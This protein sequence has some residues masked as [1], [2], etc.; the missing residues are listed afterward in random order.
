MRGELFGGL[1]ET[2]Q[3]LTRYAK[4]YGLLKNWRLFVNEAIK[5]I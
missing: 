5:T 2:E 1:Y 3:M 4:Y